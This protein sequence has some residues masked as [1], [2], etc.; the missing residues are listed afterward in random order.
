[1]ISRPSSNGC[2]L[3]LLHPGFRACG[4]CY[5]SGFLAAGV[6]TLKVTGRTQTASRLIQQ[7]RMV[8]L[9]MSSLDG[10]SWEESRARIEACTRPETEC[11]YG[12]E[13]ASVPEAARVRRKGGAV[14]AAARLARRGRAHY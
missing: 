14:G 12:K 4:L 3:A 9:M 2:E 6:R 11:L 13:I 5:A 10:L 1:L 7:A 8:D